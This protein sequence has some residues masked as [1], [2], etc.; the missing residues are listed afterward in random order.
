MLFFY[1]IADSK[2]VVHGLSE[3][4]GLLGELGLVK[5]PRVDLV[6]R[7]LQLILLVDDQAD[8]GRRRWQAQV[9]AVQ[10]SSTKSVL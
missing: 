8:G 6:E 2:P 7:A 5:L 1:H 3:R 10:R 9:Q 4:I